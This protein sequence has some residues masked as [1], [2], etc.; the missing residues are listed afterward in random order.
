MRIKIFFSF[1][2]TLFLLFSNAQ[3]IDFF[4]GSW[5]EALKKASSEDKM[6]FVDA[7][8]VWCG[9]C[10]RMAKTVFTEE[11]VGAFHNKHFINMKID[12]EKGMGIEFRQK[13]PVTAFP[14]LFYIDPTGK[15]VQ[16][17]KGFKSPEALIQ[18]GD[19]ALRNYAGNSKF[20]SMYENGQRSP[21]VVY[22]YLKAK[23]KAGEPDIKAANEYIRSQENLDTEENLKILYEACLQCDSKIFDL[24]LERKQKIIALVGKG[25]VENKINKALEATI[26]RAVT[27]ESK[28]LLAEAQHKAEIAGI[29]DPALFER[30]SNYTYYRDLQIKDEFI[31]SC[32][33]LVKKDYKKDAIKLMKINSDIVNM[34]S[35][36]KPMLLYAAEIG[37]KASKLQPSIGSYFLTAQAYYKAGKISKAQSTLADGAQF[38]EKNNKQLNANYVQM[39]ERINREL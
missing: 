17:S 25:E 34:I 18:L 13:Y 20:V 11:S 30:E 23:N 15:V 31:K 8:A 5:E 27:F 35:A 28:E 21:E 39:M 7:Y 19:L 1:F 24:F 37:E 33:E 32:K 29:A 36:D 9:P 10:K 22:N 4:Q 2:F 12:A 26:R 6:I 3:G 16:Q 14:T 38:A